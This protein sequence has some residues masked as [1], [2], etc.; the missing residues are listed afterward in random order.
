[1]ASYK[2]V[3]FL[4]FLTYSFSIGYVL[5]QKIT[6]K[7]EIEHAAI[8][9][10]YILD[11]YHVLENSHTSFQIQQISPSPTQVDISFDTIFG[12]FDYDVQIL[13]D[14]TYVLD[15]DVKRRLYLIIKRFIFPH[16]TFW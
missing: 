8:T 9:Q 6:T 14:R 1:V 16:H 7:I 10:N 13:R 4:I 12:I 2:K 15:Y 11:S 3:W 5:Q